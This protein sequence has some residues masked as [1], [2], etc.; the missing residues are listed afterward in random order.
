[1]AIY[2][3]KIKVM[4]A[5]YCQYAE[6]FFTYGVFITDDPATGKMVSYL[7]VFARMP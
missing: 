1:M 5:I 3:S 2:L 6:R 4:C 7:A